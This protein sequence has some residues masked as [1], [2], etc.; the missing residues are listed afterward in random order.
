MACP[1]GV[2]RIGHKSFEIWHDTPSNIND[3]ARA[4]IQAQNGHPDADSGERVGSKA[5]P[6][7]LPHKISS[8]EQSLLE[9]DSVAPP[10]LP[11]RESGE[12]SRIRLPHTVVALPSFK[13]AGSFKLCMRRTL[14]WRNGSV[15]FG[16]RAVWDA[17]HDLS[18]AGTLASP[19]VGLALTR[20]AACPT[21]A[22]T[23]MRTAICGG[24]RGE[25][26]DSP[27]HLQSCPA[28]LECRLV[29]LA[30]TLSHPSSRYRTKSL[31]PNLR[32]LDARMLP[33]RRTAWDLDLAPPNPFH[34]Y[35]ATTAGKGRHSR[36]PSST[37]TQMSAAS[38]SALP[39]APPS[40]LLAPSAQSRQ[41]RISNPPLLPNSL[42]AWEAFD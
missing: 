39:L 37:R 41:R 24:R 31:A 20:L 9:H 2:D 26:A 40:L 16:R 18:Q 1:T 4:R 8:D 6:S 17:S 21:S 42:A 35:V 33:G 13:P 12:E 19:S 3:R 11:A 27:C 25:W 22:L 23:T 34:A 36:F 29:T 14:I 10:W 15:C 38:P 28:V 32:A 5:E 7:P 30:T